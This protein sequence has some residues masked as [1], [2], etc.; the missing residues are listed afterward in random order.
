MFIGLSFIKRKTLI[1]AKPKP[2]LK[3]HCKLLIYSA[4]YTSVNRR[5]TVNERAL[6]EDVNPSGLFEL[7]LIDFPWD[8]KLS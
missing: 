4:I 2:H 5:F 8:L 1:G 7:T 6:A 3:F